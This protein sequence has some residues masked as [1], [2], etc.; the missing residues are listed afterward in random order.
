M[1]KRLV[2]AR[3]LSTWLWVIPAGL[4]TASCAALEPAPLP[5]YADDDDDGDDDAVGEKRDAGKADAGKADAATK[6]DAATMDAGKRDAGVKDAGKLSS[7]SLYCKAQ[8]V[9]AAHCNDCHDGEGTAGSPM[10]LT[11]YDELMAPSPSDADKKVWEVV[12][13]RIRD[14]KNPMPPRGLLKTAQ[15][16]DLDEWIAADA[17]DSDGAC[18]AP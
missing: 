12:A 16:K 4:A 14:A 15:R 18:A 8:A 2:V 6:G 7:S 5:S 11:T 1:T 17:P 9:L 13:E 10:G 3:T